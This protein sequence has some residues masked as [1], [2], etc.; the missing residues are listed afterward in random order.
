MKY[1]FILLVFVVGNRLLG[2]TANSWV[3]KNDFAGFKRE[4][5]VSFVVNEKGYITTGV[6]TSETVLK[7]LWEYN[8][9][10]DSWTQRADLPGSGRR[11]A[12]GFAMNGKG[13]VGTG[14]D[15]DEATIGV[16]LTDFW[17]YNP[18]TNNWLQ[19]ANF[20]G[21][22]GDGIYY[23]TGFSVE[24]KGYVCGGKIGPN[25][26]SDELWEYKPAT[27]QWTQRTDFPGGVR[28]N[29]S[30]LT[31]GN[32]A[33]IGLGTDQNVYRYD[34]WQYNPGNNQ[35]TQKN[36]FI[37]GQR[38]GASTFEL[39]GNGYVC[40]GTNGGIKDDL[41]MYIPEIDSWYPRA[42]Y[43][44]SKRKQAISFA[45]NNVGYVGTGAGVNGKKGSMYAYIPMESLTL[46]ENTLQ[47][48]TFPN[49]SVNTIQISS[50]DK[51]ICRIVLYNLAGQQVYEVTT[52]SK[53]V[54]VDRNQLPAGTYTVLVAL[55]NGAHI[56]KSTIQ[57]ID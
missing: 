28:Y 8:P 52:A 7:D 20:P 41:F 55:D 54:T 22:T 2:Q 38:A 36:H 46:D 51:V 31:I 17:E 4:Q 6:D 35:W 53:V 49:P 16:K 24:G 34:W 9:T 5:A 30:S 11:N 45:I 3:K 43:G 39:F 48:T 56:S 1:V 18:L 37:G 57:F 50:E 15:N 32:V 26:Y 42:N 40:L 12:I 14:I 19:K 25:N 23:A 13:Y 47:V 33:Y 10:N 27:N 21:A 29:L 44:G